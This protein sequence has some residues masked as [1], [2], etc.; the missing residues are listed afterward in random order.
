M[1]LKWPLLLLPIIIGIGVA[2]WY[3]MRRTRYGWQGELPY[4]ARSYRLTALPE[5]QRALRLH[6]RLSVAALVMS[7]VAVFMLLGATLRPTKTYEPQL[8]GSDTPHVD[9]MLCFGPLYSIRLSDGLAIGQLATI[10]REKV[11]G[12]GNQRIGMTKEFQRN[13]PVTSD[14]PWVEQRLGEIAKVAEQASSE[15]DPSAKYSVD[16]E[17]FE[18]SFRTVSI[19]DTLAMCAMGLPAVGSD[20][21][22]GRTIIYVGSTENYESNP[23]IYSDAMLAGIV[24]DA[25]IQV[26][27]IVP[28]TQTRE[29]VDKLVKDSGGRQYLYTEVGGYIDTDVTPKKIDNQKDE[30]SSALDKI[31]S[32]PPQS[33]LDDRRKD[34]QHP[35][36]WDVPDLLLQIALIAA[37]VLAAA[38]LG[39]RL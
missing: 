21:G 32:N 14:L 22:R 13:F 33:T 8:A 27:T 36:Q 25:K 29:F 1:G 39:M 6:E 34:E 28:G 35:F 38:R 10:L 23:P 26:N 31:L 5:Y 7:V 30:L 4:L 12:F 2:V 16:T 3:A 19:N 20:N 9:I 17:V 11:E 37:V 15:D 24:K 18:G